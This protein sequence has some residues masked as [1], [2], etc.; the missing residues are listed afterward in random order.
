MESDLIRVNFS[1]SAPFEDCFCSVLSF[2][3]TSN[4]HSLHSIFIPSN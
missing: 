1:F 3:K 2:R 4:V